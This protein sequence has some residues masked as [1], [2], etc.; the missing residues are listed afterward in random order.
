MVDLSP[1]PTHHGE[2]KTYKCHPKVKLKVVIC[3]VC[4]EAYHPSDFKRD[5]GKVISDILGICPEHESIKLTSTQSTN[6][7]E[8]IED[9]KEQM[10]KK[11]KEDNLK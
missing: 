7:K 9:V 4:E 3:L 10:L 2:N 11:Y 6:K 5:G 8:K 1:G